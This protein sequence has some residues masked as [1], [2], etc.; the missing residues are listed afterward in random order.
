MKLTNASRYGIAALVHLAR[1]KPNTPLAS[2]QIAHLDGLPER[3][4]L[5]VLKNLVTAGVLR[6]LKGPNGG[7]LLARPPQGVTLLEVVEAIDGPIRGRAEPLGGDAPDALTKRLQA[8]CDQVAA[9]VHRIL[10]QV[11]IADLAKGK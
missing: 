5:K 10:G 2:H 9:E 6:S 7:Y 1:Q 11:R 3:F 4:L 8:V